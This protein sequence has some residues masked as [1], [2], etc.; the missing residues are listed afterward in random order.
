[1]LPSSESK[2]IAASRVSNFTIKG[3]GQGRITE[4]EEITEEE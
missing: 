2:I 3:T 1:M 4:E